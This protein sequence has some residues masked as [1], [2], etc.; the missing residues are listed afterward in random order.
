[1][2]EPPNP[3]MGALRYTLMKQTNDAIF[4][5]KWN[6]ANPYIYHIMKDKRKVMRDNMTNAESFLWEYIRSK[7]L[8]VKFRR[9]HVIGNYIPDF[10]ALTSKLIIEVDGEIHKYQ[11]EEDEHRTYELNEKGFKV[12][13]FTNNEIFKDINL[14]LEKI[15]AELH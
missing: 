4:L 9:Q 6:T 14:V 5:P 12:I 11:I 3:Q 7:K 13:R 2:L 15:K 8:G 1:M 10:V